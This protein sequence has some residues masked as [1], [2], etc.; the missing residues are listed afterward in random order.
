MKKIVFIII[1][2]LC[3]F[4]VSAVSYGAPYR[5]AGGAIYS[6]HHYGASVGSTL[7]QVPVATMHSTTR[8]LSAT[9]PISSSETIVAG[10]AKHGIYT[11]ASEVRGG[12][13][14]DET[15]GG[16][17]P[18]V[19][20]S[21]GSG[22]PEPC[23]GCVDENGDFICDVCGHDIYE[24]EC[25]ENC[26]CNVPLEFGIAE[27]LFMAVIAGAY[28]LYKIYKVKKYYGEVQDSREMVA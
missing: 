8:A 9:Q 13:T 12:V 21:G 4:T 7:A 25:G 26:H 15:G 23:P 24:C 10:T 3:A 1:G 22:V 16:Y 17:K 20:K 11:S 2:L 19:R 5:G 28:A 18:S 6:T 27:W 14:T